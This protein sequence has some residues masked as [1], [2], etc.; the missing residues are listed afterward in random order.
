MK[1]TSLQTLGPRDVPRGE[2]HRLEHV[3]AAAQPEEGE[4]VLGP[5]VPVEVPEGGG[6]ALEVLD[7][8]RV[9]TR[10]PLGDAEQSRRGGKATGVSGDAVEHA[11]PRPHGRP[12]LP[13]HSRLL[14]HTHPA[15]V[16]EGQ[17]AHLL[18]SLLVRK[19]KQDGDKTWH[20]SSPQQQLLLLGCEQERKRF[21]SVPFSPSQLV[22]VSHDAVVVE[23]KR[24]E[25][26]I[27]SLDLR[28][29]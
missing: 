10:S 6:A 4:P 13:D 3:R 11:L 28:L 14:R 25:V 16:A 20:R 22:S 21:E 2:P 5:F 29:S 9:L 15:E 19:P 26:H 1:H 17:E 12:P 7:A 24:R 23:T 27:I 18:Q 8:D